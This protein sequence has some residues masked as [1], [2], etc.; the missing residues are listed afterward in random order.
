MQTVSRAP[1]RLIE[2][3]EVW[4]PNAGSGRRGGMTDGRRHWTCHQ[5]NINMHICFE[6]EKITIM[7][8]LPGRRVTESATQGFQFIGCKV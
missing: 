5:M 7:R 6:C 1:A 3:T 8:I 2:L 4:T